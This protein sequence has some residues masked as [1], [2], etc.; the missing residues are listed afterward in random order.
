MYIKKDKVASNFET[1]YRE[2]KAEIKKDITAVALGE[3]NGNFFRTDPGDPTTSAKALAD[4][5][6]F[7]NGDADGKPNYAPDL[8]SGVL[9]DAYLATGAGTALPTAN[10][11]AGQIGVYW[12][13]AKD[14]SGFVEV[15]LPNYGPTG[16][17][18][19]PASKTARGE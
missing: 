2:V 19:T 13:A 12:N 5:V 16:A 10:Q 1:A 3:V 15:Y 11:N 8:L 4:L 17:K 14:N 18:L 9:A 6:N 7:L